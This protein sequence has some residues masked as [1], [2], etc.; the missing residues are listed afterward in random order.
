MS[1]IFTMHEFDADSLIKSQRAV[2]LPFRLSVTLD[3]AEPRTITVRE[4]L[5]LLP[6]KRL[7]LIADDGH[8]KVFIK[9][10]IGKAAKKYQQRE[11]L[12]VK[13][14]HSA[15]VATPR[16]VWQGR[17]KGRGQGL[18]LAFEYIAQATGLREAFMNVED[19]G[20]EQV[21]GSV[22]EQAGRLTLMT[23][24]MSAIAK[25]HQSGATQADIHLDNFLIQGE[26][27]YM[28]D[29]G[30][31]LRKTQTALSEAKSLDNL[32]QFFAQFQPRFDPL[33]PQALE[34]YRQH[35][36]WQEDES[37]ETHLHNRLQQYRRARRAKYIQKAFRDCTRIAC[38]SSFRCFQACE[39]QYD[40][41]AMRGLLSNLDAAI[42]QARASGNLLKDGNTATL[43][44]YE[45]P[46]GP[47]VIKRYN[48][49]SVS[50]RLRRAFRKSRA[51]VSWGNIFRLELLGVKTAEPIALVEERFGPLR[52]RAYL[53]TKYIAGS[54]A[55]GLHALADPTPA[56]QSM[57]EILHTLTAACVTHGDLKASNFLLGSEGV[58]LI[59]LDS[60]TEHQPGR[61]FTSSAQK[62]LARFMK[63]WASSPPLSSRF[64][65]L[66][67]DLV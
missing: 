45:S 54:D 51:W 7:A 49:K 61:S 62:D 30:A 9:L 41:P 44:R 53:V 39:R 11:L 32:A 47:L 57:A 25:L 43:V 33:I 28:I 2:K 15:Q 26:R 58:A 64:T 19:G 50:H 38:H 12:G 40:T 46:E 10:F 66:L 4:I 16:L 55:S 21:E 35:R 6:G 24:G 14:M 59:D 18:V 20:E 48:L 27:L 5:R 65:A 29:G 13:L 3:D 56:T 52:L 8:R 60:M 23:C 36:G 22:E 34:S 63:N 17:L 37:R 1:H 67:K 31:I 42:D